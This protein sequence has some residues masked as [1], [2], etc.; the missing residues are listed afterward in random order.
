MG[1]F[2]GVFTGMVPLKVAAQFDKL[3]EKGHR[4][5]EKK[6]YAT[7][8]KIYEKSLA[9]KFN[10]EARLNLASAYLYLHRFPE[11]TEAYSK[12]IQLNQ[13]P[14][15]RYLEFADLYL[16]AGVPN[17]AAAMVARY[18]ER[19]STHLTALAMAESI[20]RQN[21]FY[22]DSH[23]VSIRPLPYN[24][25]QSDLFPLQW[26][27]QPALLSARQNR[28]QQQPFTWHL[29][30]P[31]TIFSLATGSP[32]A[33][34]LPLKSGL[35]GPVAIDTVHDELFVTILGSPRDAVSANKAADLRLNIYYAKRTEKG[36]SEFRSLPV[37]D[38]YFNVGH[39][40]LSPDGNRL[41]YA[42][43]NPDG[44]GGT[45]LYYID[46]QPGGIWSEPIALPPTINSPRNELLP[47]V[48]P[49]GTLCFSSDGLGGLGGLDI[50][51]V[52]SSAKSWFP[53]NV[54]APINSRQD[55]YGLLLSPYPDQGLF[56]SERRGKGDF[57]SVKLDQPLTTLGVTLKIYGREAKEEA[58]AE[59]NT[60]PELIDCFF[61][62]TLDMQ[63]PSDPVA[64]E[65]APKESDP[66]ATSD[67]LESDESSEVIFIGDTEPSEEVENE[68]EEA[69]AEVENE[70][71]AMVD[72]VE[73][74]EEIVEVV[75]TEEIVEEVAE[76]EEIVEAEEV[77]EEE[78]AENAA[79]AEEVVE[80]VEESMPTESIADGNLAPAAPGED[81]ETQESA[82]GRYSIQL[83]V[84]S[85]EP[86]PDFFEALGP[87]RE[88]VWTEARGNLTVYRL[89]H[90][91][92]RDIAYKNL[93]RI[94]GRGFEDAFVYEAP[95]FVPEEKSEP[96]LTVPAETVPEPVEEETVAVEVEEEEMS[97]NEGKE[98]ETV[99]EEVVKEAIAEEEIVPEPPVELPAMTDNP[100]FFAVQIGAFRTAP[101]QTFRQKLG[102]ELVG[103]LWYVSAGDFQ[104]YSIGKF[105]NYS[106]AL[107]ALRR[108]KELFPDAF[109]TG[110]N[111]DSRVTV[112]EAVQML[113]N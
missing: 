30:Q 12:I 94:K 24:S 101:D 57:Y 64:E 91:K 21:E 29:P 25:P 26:E 45:D 17:R 60:D 109:L 104:R 41:Y 31:Y 66:Y 93:D 82:I 85:R 108:A 16:R 9:K 19:D 4:A 23:L 55:D 68:V 102:E 78:I 92:E 50:Y 36:W 111:G 61:T 28:K 7:A 13:F 42:S 43:D 3:A 80:V 75:E 5:F 8:I 2:L 88:T 54:G 58:I 70:T 63:S 106:T 100:V 49:F 39:P 38:P 53:V 62:D 32:K 87:Y 59:T 40:A 27:G 79:V 73:V 112:A 22:R 81:E 74:V 6:D 107:A 83:G 103:Q 14:P 65:T 34:K 47:T 76:V 52:E 113:Q 69:V 18:Y 15:V 1:L 90:I 105:T 48:D 71:G 56:A 11:A 67:F 110:Y 98:N 10:K 44:Q 37:N 20:L 77:V 95:T 96:D 86:N 51:Y 72:T 99:A 84:F 35:W 89:G 33:I 46:R 97:E